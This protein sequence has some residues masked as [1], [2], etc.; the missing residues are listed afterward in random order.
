MKI[1][2]NIKLKLVIFVGFI[3][4]LFSFAAGSWQQKMKNASFYGIFSFIHPE[5]V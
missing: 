4:E 1:L 2:E 3:C 5:N